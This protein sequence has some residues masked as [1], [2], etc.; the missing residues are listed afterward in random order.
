MSTL[1]ESAT[2][3][4]ITFLKLYV[5]LKCV[6]CRCGIGNL[7]KPSR[8]LGHEN[9]SEWSQKV[10]LNFEWAF[11]FSW[12]SVFTRFISR[13]IN[14]RKNLQL[15]LLINNLFQ[16]IVTALQSNASYNLHISTFTE[17]ELVIIYCYRNY[18][19][20]LDI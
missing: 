13:N 9:Y 16:P 5:C 12:N 18:N 15:R 20:Q 1:Y 11:S 10:E 6:N 4:L 8:P 17:L 3:T 14:Y 19:F 7:I 2:V